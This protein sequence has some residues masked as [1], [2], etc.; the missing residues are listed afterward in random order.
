MA[1]MVVA[2]SMLTL[3]LRL[4]EW[5]TP[6]FCHFWKAEPATVA[7]ALRLTMVPWLKLRVKL[8]LPPAAEFLSGGL[9]ATGAPDDGEDSTTRLWLGTVP[10][11]RTLS[12]TRSMLFEVV[13]VSRNVRVV[14]VLLAVKFKVLALQLVL[15]PPMPAM[16]KVWVRRVEEPSNLTSMRWELVL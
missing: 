3:V 2:A 7:G 10:I 13:E 5:S 6:F 8:V 15:P 16:V 1:L 12:R 4:V 14:V 9:I 11:T